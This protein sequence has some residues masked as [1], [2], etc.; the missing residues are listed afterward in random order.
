MFAHWIHVV[1]V[2]WHEVEIAF[3]FGTWYIVQ[4]LPGSNSGYL[5]YKENR[6]SFFFFV[7]GGGFIEK[8]KRFFGQ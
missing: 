2:V 8:K 7:G 5:G 1:K 3:Q 4:Q 6:T